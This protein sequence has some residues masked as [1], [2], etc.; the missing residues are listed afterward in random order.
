MLM[1]GRNT[2]AKQQMTGQKTYNNRSKA[3][4]HENQS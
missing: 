2:N 4:L 1:A 3:P